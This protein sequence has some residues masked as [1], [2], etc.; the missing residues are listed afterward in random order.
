[1]SGNVRVVHLC[2]FAAPYPGAFVPALQA[3]RRRVE[4]RGWSFEAAFA[5][6]ADR[7]PW[8]HDAL[9]DGMRVRTAPRLPRRAERAWVAALL[10]ER[11]GPVVLH[12]HF[13]HWDAPALIAA[14]T[15]RRREP[16]AVIWHEHGLLSRRPRSIARNVVRFGL[17]GRAVDAQLCVGPA[18][19]AQV[20]ARGAPR[21][22]TM[23]FPNGLDHSRW[24]RASREQRIEAR[25][26]LGVSPDAEVLVSFQ[27]NWEW[28]GGSLLVG[29][30]REL[31]DRGRPV[32]AVI[33]GGGEAA[34]AAAS[35]LGLERRVEIV[36][37]RPE[38]E[39]FF[40]A[41]DVFVAP[42]RVEALGWSPLE[43]LCC[44][45]PVVASD[46]AGHRHF[47]RHLEAM[48]L[49]PLDARAIADAVQRELGAEPLDRER[50]IESSRAYLERHASVDEWVDRVMHLY[51]DVLTRRHVWSVSATAPA[52]KGTEGRGVG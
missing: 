51:E 39:V 47:G 45:T 31:V 16:V 34:R 27:W 13:S 8:Y 48:R 30:V 5:P 25:R 43:A 37:P 23:L 2:D 1:M 52:S 17:L 44:G 35:R 49:T 42:S 9:R 3:I 21:R 15:G 14:R 18:A 50:R 26:E 24:Q 11:S 6:A 36:A 38:P 41:A 10:A 7:H 33:V 12:T 22:R 32:C 28:K 19:Y 46:L 4:D 29:A 20:L 40:A